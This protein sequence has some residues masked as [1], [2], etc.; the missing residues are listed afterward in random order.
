MAFRP[1]AQ[2]FDP[3]FINSF[4]PTEYTERWNLEKADW[5]A[6]Q[7]LA[8]TS[9]NVADQPDINQAYKHLKKT[10]FD[11]SCR[12]IPKMKLNSTKRPCLPWWN[13]ECKTE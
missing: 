13:Q 11:T 3:N 5:E 4:I 9:E 10:I 6:Y 2:G 7:D 12:T 8:A 1:P